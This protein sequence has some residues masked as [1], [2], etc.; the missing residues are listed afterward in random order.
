YTYDLTGKKLSETGSLT[1]WQ[2]DGGGRMVR[3]TRVPTRKDWCRMSLG[4]WDA[5]DL[6]AWADLPACDPALDLAVTYDALGNILSE[7]VEG[8]PRTAHYDHNRIAS[9]S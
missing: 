1:T 6:Q 5:L 2:Y 8:S 9:R 7:V 4:E 3:E